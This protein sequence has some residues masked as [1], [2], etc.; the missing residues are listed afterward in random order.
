MKYDFFKT[1]AFQLDPEFV[2]EKMLLFFRAFP[3]F[4]ASLFPGILDQE[5]IY[6]I[7]STNLTWK[8]PIG[9]AAGFDKNGLIV[10]YLSS[11]GFGA[12]EVGTVTPQPQKGNPRPRIFRYPSEK[13]LRNFMGIP[14]QGQEAVWKNL[15]SYG[16]NA[17]LGINIGKNTHTP[18]DQAP[19]DY[20]Q[21]YRKFA[22]I[23]NYLVMNISCPNVPGGRKFQDREKLSQLLRFLSEIRQQS[24]VPLFIK[25]APDLTEDDLKELVQIVWEHRLSGIIATNTIHD[26]KRGEGGISGDLLY[27]KAAQTRQQ[28]LKLT[29]SYSDID[30]IGVGGFSN[31][32]QILEFWKQG[33]KFV[34][35][36]TSFIDQGPEILHQIKKGIDQLLQT[37]KVQTL[38]ELMNY[39]S[40][41]KKVELE[42][43]ASLKG[44]S[45]SP[46]LRSVPDPLPFD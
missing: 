27:E 38:Q 45:P 42:F 31:F 32:E 3:K 34:Q 29:A 44:P 23:A 5:N 2:H 40:Q 21:L 16:G 8:F 18:E 25:I 14:N 17:T 22:P 46:H 1:L 33:G 6:Q 19:V 9:M 10:N 35:I 4:S 20:L 13:S 15:Q 30:I 41:V 39:T 12:I 36:Y 43:R 28:L 24:P 26:P 7:K 11:L 37:Q